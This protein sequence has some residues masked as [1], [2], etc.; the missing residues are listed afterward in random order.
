MVG[1]MKIK[2]T[3]IE[4]DDHKNL[5]ASGISNLTTITFVYDEQKRKK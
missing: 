2:E 5:A 1:P 3:S 4:L